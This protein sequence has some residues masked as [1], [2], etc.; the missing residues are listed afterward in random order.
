MCGI[1]SHCLYQL[2]IQVC[3]G[4]Y[5]KS[6]EKTG[7]PEFTCRDKIRWLDILKE[8]V[9]QSQLLRYRSSKTGHFLLITPR[10]RVANK[11]GV[12][13]DWI[14]FIFEKILFRSFLDIAVY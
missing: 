14:F 2:A 7:V 11:A 12:R 6:L 9:V 5:L 4:N 1:I 3:S 13:R 8:F 10:I